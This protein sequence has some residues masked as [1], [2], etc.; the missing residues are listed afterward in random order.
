MAAIDDL[1]K[2]LALIPGGASIDQK[3]M[4]F[5]QYIKDAAKAGALEAVPQIKLQVEATVKP[6]VIASLALGA[7]SFLL[8]ASMWLKQN[9]K[10]LR[11]LE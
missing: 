6:Y 3:L 10:G 4:E 9:P 1:R 5:T 7:G 11:L 2:L 8:F